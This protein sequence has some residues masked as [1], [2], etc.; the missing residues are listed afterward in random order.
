MR[1][2]EPPQDRYKHAHFLC[3]PRNV[4]VSG[5][6]F[7]PIGKFGM[8]LHEM[9]EVSNLPMGSLPYEELEQLEKKEPTLYEI[10]RELMCH[11]YIC[12]DLHPSCRTMNGLK[13]YVDYLFSVV[14]G[15]LKGLHRNS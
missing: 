3:H 7:T 14:G 6:F 13:T 10:Y 5:T 2:S 12:L 15:P 8:V 1:P 11:F 9:W 4:S